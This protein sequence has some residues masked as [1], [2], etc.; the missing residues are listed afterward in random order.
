MSRPV[1]RLKSK[2]CVSVA[3]GWCVA[4]RKKKKRKGKERKGR[5]SREDRGEERERMTVNRS[6]K[7]NECVCGEEKR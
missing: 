3:C 2:C 4:Q 7:K 5:L 1:Y 6:A